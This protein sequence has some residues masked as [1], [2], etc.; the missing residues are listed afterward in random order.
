MNQTETRLLT[1]PSLTSEYAIVSMP[2]TAWFWLDDLVKTRFPAGGYKAMV[3][4]FGG[5]TK[6]PVI[7][8]STLRQKAQEHCDA[9]MADLYDLTNDNI[10]GEGYGE[11]KRNPSL[12]S[13]PDISASMPFAYQ[14][15]TFIPHATYL[16]TVWQR[17]NY[18]LK[19]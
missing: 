1:I 19:D 16:T 8:S 11:M 7:L 14:L 13:A 10:P 4:E 12:P 6:D 18:H 9:Q 2:K 15:F 5:G 3:R 17:R